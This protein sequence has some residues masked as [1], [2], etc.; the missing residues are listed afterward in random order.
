MRT[1]ISVIAGAALIA[2]VSVLPAVAQDTPAASGEVTLKGM[3]L[4]NVHTGERE[5]SVCIYVLDGPAD[6]KAE[7]DKIMADCYPEKGL[8]GD[9]ARKLMDEFTANLRY[10]IDGPIADKLREDATYNARQV[11]AVTGVIHEKDGKKWI[12]ASKCEDSTFDYP[13]IMLAPDKPFVMPDREPLTLKVSDALSIK[14]IFAP[15]GK[16]FMGEPYYMCPHWQ[17]D[18]PHMVT[19]TKGYYMGECPV[20]WEIYNAVTGAAAVEGQAAQSPANV[21]CADMYDFCR[22][23]SEKSGRTVRIPAA[24]EWDYAAR[25]GTSNPPFA[26]KYASQAGDVNKGVKSGT[27]NAWGFYDMFSTGWERVSDSSSVLDRHDT[28]D[29]THIP[30]EDAGLADKHASHGHM[31]K[32]NSGYAIGEFEYIQS[33]PCDPAVYPGIV[34]FRVVVED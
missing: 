28:T 27:P 18:P 23:L 12:T 1:C 2:F 24:A 7:F 21:S 3:V 25:V 6:I 30:P 10:F 32:G 17:E 9:A 22:M 15:A 34:R 8:D 5:P 11:R 26:A 16:F 33:E 19:L 4:N 29:P 31:A 20:T 13:A 14:C